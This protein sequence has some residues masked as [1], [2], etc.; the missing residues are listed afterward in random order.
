[1]NPWYKFMQ[2]ISFYDVNGFATGYFFNIDKS[3]ETSHTG[4]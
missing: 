3:Y 1:M 2:N 4:S